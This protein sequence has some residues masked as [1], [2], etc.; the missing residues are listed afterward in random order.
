VVYFADLY[1][2]RTTGQF[3]W[4]EQESVKNTCYDDGVDNWMQQDSGF[5]IIMPGAVAGLFLVAGL[6][7]NITA[8]GIP[9]G[10]FVDILYS[11]AASGSFGVYRAD[12]FVGSTINVTFPM[13]GN[14]DVE[15]HVYTHTCDYG[16]TEKYNI[17]V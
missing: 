14:Y 17:D 4:V 7:Y 10:T 5:V 9:E 11:G 8:Y 2:L 6:T 16:N 13:A 1:R 15:F 3:D 12:E